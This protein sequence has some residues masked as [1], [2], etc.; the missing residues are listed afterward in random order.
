MPATFLVDLKN[1]LTGDVSICQ[2]FA[3]AT[4]G[5]EGS[6]IDMLDADGPVFGILQMGS[7]TGSGVDIDVKLQECATTNG[8]YTDM[9]TSGGSFS[10]SYT[11]STADNVLDIIN[12]R[13]TARYVRAYAVIAGTTSVTSVPLTVSIVGQKKIMGSGTGYQ[14]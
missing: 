5:H 14:S 8:T 6:Y 11:E 12:A 13:R 2:T 7:V 10:Q 9:D 4:A 1:Q 3:A